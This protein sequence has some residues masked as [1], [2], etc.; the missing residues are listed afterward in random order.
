M[1][2]TVF[3]AYGLTKRYRKT[4]ALDCVDMAV[5]KSDIYGF[6][7][8]NGA[9]KTTLIRIL[10]GL[11]MKTSGEISLN[12]ESAEREVAR[13]RQRVGFIVETPAAY[14]YMTAAENLEVQRLQRGIPGKSCIERSLKATGLS[15]VGKKKA[16]DFSL[17]MKQRLGLAMALL[18]E[19]EFLVLDEPVNGLDPTGIVEFREILKKLNKE[20]GVTILI[21][22]H[23]LSELYMLATCFGFIHKGKLLEQISVAELD[24]RCKKHLAIKVDDPGKAVFLLEN[25]LL[26]KRF[27]AMPNKTIKVYER[28]GE[29]AL[30]SRELILGGVMVEDMTTKGDDLEAYYMR[31]IGGNSNA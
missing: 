4:V 6:I 5:K 17:G 1:R 18:S 25:K 31:L 8:E 2:E 9:G 15:D 21:S 19:P 30:I 23:L 22:S 13:Q 24:E 11:A 26:I 10:S 3:G 7:G 29:S 16:R 14:P 12:G 27:E 20:R 28:L